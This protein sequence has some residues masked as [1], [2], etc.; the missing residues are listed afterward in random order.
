MSRRRPLLIRPGLRAL[1]PLALA[2]LLAACAGRT[3]TASL[4]EAQHY[5]AAAK[6]RYAPPGPP[7]DPWGP[8]IQEAA[9]RFDVPQSWIRGVMHRESNGR[10]FNANGLLTISDKGAMGLM[11]VMPET[12]DE[13]RMR[14]GF[15][16]DPYNPH[17]NIL[18][19]TAFLRELYDK[20]GMPGLLA[21]YD[22]GPG[23][24]DQYLA[25]K[26]P[27]PEETR[28]YVAAIAPLIERDT[29][30]HPSLAS[31]L[32][33]NRLPDEIPAGLRYRRV[34][35]LA[36]TRRTHGR[37]L[38]R[39]AAAT[40]AGHSALAHALS[41]PAS[42]GH[43]AAGHNAAGRGP[44]AHAAPLRLAAARPL[45]HRHGGGYWL[46]NSAA[47]AT[48]PARDSGG[49]AGWAIQLGAFTRERDARQALG[50]VR[51]LHGGTPQ[52]GI[53]HHG[54]T[55]LYRARLTGLTR[56]AALD[57]CTRLRHGACLVLSPA[58]QS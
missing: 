4:T 15:G 27:L 24:L 41:G 51:R 30:V 2:A 52:L 25:N 9:T 58:S 36:R 18:A 16:D 29:P 38:M 45:P 20:Y 1:V 56:L 57:A 48:L 43:N 32:A 21:A 54:H 5:V 13:L 11:Q 55:T 6:P 39:L 10:E 23:R 49:S 44:L 17:N 31:E 14:Y 37:H 7:T 19:G 46:M 35:R 12:F 50:A 53:A 3:P 26:S 40:P 28:A 8:Y 33:L 22:A 34:V 42:P 47:A